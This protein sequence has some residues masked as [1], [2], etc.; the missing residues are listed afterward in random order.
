MERKLNTVGKELDGLFK[1][2]NTIVV[3]V[4]PLTFRQRELEVH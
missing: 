1:N 3:K 2:M 4:D